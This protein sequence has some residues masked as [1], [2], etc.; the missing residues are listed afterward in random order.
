MTTRAWIRA[1]STRWLSRT[2]ISF[3]LQIRLMPG[4]VRLM[5]RWASTST[6]KPSRTRWIILR[7][8]PCK[9]KWGTRRGHCTPIRSMRSP[10][11]KSAVHTRRARRRYFRHRRRW[12]VEIKGWVTPFHRDTIKRRA[13]LCI[14]TSNN[15]PTEHW[16]PSAL[17]CSTIRC[18]KQSICRGTKWP[19][20]R[21]STHTSLMDPM[22]LCPQDWAYNF[23]IRRI[24]AMRLMTE[25]F[26]MH[27]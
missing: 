3:I 27:R 20:V 18:K 1:W 6:S 14:T 22:E 5:A 12:P 26:R 13:K 4:A 9:I 21:H 16:N 2:I 24:I 10:W 15:K 23:L 17:K 11:D 19:R 7:E 25:V 8:C